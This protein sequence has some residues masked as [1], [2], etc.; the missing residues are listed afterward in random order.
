MPRE[1]ITIQIGQCGMQLGQSFWQLALE[2]HSENLSKPYY[3]DALST[4]FRNIDLR[5]GQELTNKNNTNIP[6]SSLKA[7]SILVDMETGVINSV[8]K[9]PL[10]D[11]FDTNQIISDQSGSGNNWSHGYCYYGPKYHDELLEII[12]K[13]VEPCDSLQSFFL[14]HSLGGGTGSGLGTYILKLLADEY[15]EI[16]RFVSAIFPSDN[17]DVITSPYNSVLALNQLIHY[18]D[19][20]LPI[21]NQSLLDISK[22]SRRDEAKKKKKNVHE[23]PFNDMNR[24]AAHLLT[25]L[26]CSMR[27]EGAL[28]VDLNEITMNLV[29]YPNLKFLISSM[30]PCHTL[31]HQKKKKPFNL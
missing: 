19:C 12:R 24:I 4:F 13:T 15:A 18:A 22:Y 14:L 11:L 1:L 30:S 9:G 31:L 8:L 28:N 27:F 10:R 25:N 23:N 21:D 20:V 29:P 16:Y 3:T 2:E 5:T 26:T 6:I 7:R 17:D